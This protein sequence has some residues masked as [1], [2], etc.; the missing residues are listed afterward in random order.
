MEKGTE[1]E[2]EAE[3]KRGKAGAERERKGK[4]EGGGGLFGEREETCKRER[5]AGINIVKEQ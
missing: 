2:R 5:A 1:G 4:V 3:K